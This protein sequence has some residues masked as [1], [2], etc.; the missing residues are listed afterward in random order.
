[1]RRARLLLLLIRTVP[2]LICLPLRPLRLLLRCLLLVQPQQQGVRRH[3]CA[4]C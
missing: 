4:L 1:M 3:S 2:A